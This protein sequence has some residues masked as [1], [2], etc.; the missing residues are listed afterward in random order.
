MHDDPSRN[1]VFVTETHTLIVKDAVVKDAGTYFCRDNTE[2]DQY[3]NEK[4]TEEDLATFFKVP[5]R[6]LLFVRCF[7]F[8]CLFVCKY[9][10]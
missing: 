10:D 1:R 4:M 2:K 8:V 3:F 5:G 6:Y 7:A 9:L